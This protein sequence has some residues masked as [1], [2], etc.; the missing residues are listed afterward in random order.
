MG[1]FDYIRS[2][3]PLPDGFEGELQ[4]KNFRCELATH[5]IRADGRLILEILDHTEEV[6]REERPYPNDDGFRGLFG[7]L[8]S[9]WRH[10]DANFHGIVNFY[11]RGDRWH[12]Y[13]AK[14]TDGQLVEIVALLEEPNAV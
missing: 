1:M 14:F 13:N 8:R 11:G 6:P 3:V 4:T 9:V 5:V 12:E 7:S 2:E 10:E